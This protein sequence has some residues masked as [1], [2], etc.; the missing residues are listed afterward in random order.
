MRHILKAGL[1]ILLVFASACGSSKRYAFKKKVHT[2]KA[3]QTPTS[4]KNR[5]TETL[6]S[7]SR[8][9][10]YADVV[11]QYIHDYSGIAV[12]Q[13]REFGVP[14]SITLAQGILESGAGR[15]E[16]T[17]KAN[18]HFGIKCHAGWNGPS[19]FH[20]DD[21]RGECFRKYRKP[22]ESFRDHSLFL[23]S[24]SRYGALFT[25]EKDDYKGWA[26]GLKSAGYAT[27]P[28]Y[29]AKL[30]SIIERY[31]LYRF[32]SEVTGRSRSV[33]YDTGGSDRIHIVQKGDTLYNI[34]KRY[35]IDVETLKRM[36]NLS[37]N[38]IQIGQKLNV[39]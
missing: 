18:N 5:D 6:E 31:E 21:A 29:P 28:R 37:D 22:E 14:A 20:D 32:D 9:T 26:Y 35:Q 17:Q 23:T 13:M 34:S 39:K 10:V 12:S 15:G 33:A 38:N 11:R 27:D 24:R 2:P 3:E 4:E 25:L 8:T 16:L 36:N 7:T 1:L 19:V 30:I